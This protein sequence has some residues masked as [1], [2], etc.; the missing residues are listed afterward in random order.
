MYLSF[1]SCSLCKEEGAS[2]HLITE[3]KA[4]EHLG[5]HSKFFLKKSSKYLKIACRVCGGPIPS[6][7]ETAVSEH[8]ETFHPTECFASEEDFDDQA[9]SIQETCSKSRWDSSIDSDPESEDERNGNNVRDGDKS[10]VNL[11]TNRGDACNEEQD[12][13]ENEMEI[14]SNRPELEE[15][16]QNDNDFHLNNKVMNNNPES[17][18]S[19]SNET[20]A[21][22][23]SECGKDNGMAQIQP[24]A[25]NLLSKE[26]KV[27][28]TEEGRKV[29]FKVTF[30]DTNKNAQTQYHH[31]DRAGECEFNVCHKDLECVD[32]FY[33]FYANQT[34]LHSA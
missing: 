7:D 10:S 11:E 5:E 8:Y 13:V 28:S 17:V 26:N 24:L 30:G 21:S 18:S 6:A 20:S 33:V 29:D 25:N 31:L 16:G 19:E 34:L 1:E 12:D 22:E 23:T 32:S 2:K 27:I 15:G 3:D 14:T 9:T 4:L